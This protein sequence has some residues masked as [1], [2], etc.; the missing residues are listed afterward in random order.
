MHPGG[1][2]LLPNRAYID[3]GTMAML[4]NAKVA[5]FDLSVGDPIYEDDTEEP[6]NP[7]DPDNPETP[8]DPGDDQQSESR[9]GID[10]TATISNGKAEIYA[11]DGR[12]IETDKLQKG[13]YIID[14]RKVIVK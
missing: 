4:T 6:V 11:L 8:D 2:Y 14:N 3:S 7:D 12:K 9:L 13:I 10:E 5:A 1:N